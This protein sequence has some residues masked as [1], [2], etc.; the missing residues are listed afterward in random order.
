MKID[1][2]NE[3]KPLS[4][5]IVP[6][7]PKTGQIKINNQYDLA[8]GATEPNS[9]A[10]IPIQR[11][12]LSWRTEQIM[13]LIDVANADPNIVSI[14]FDISTPGG[15]VTNTDL[16][17]AKIKSSAKPTVGYV[18]DMVASAGMWIASAMNYRIASSALDRA[19]SIGTM[20]RVMDMTRMYRDK[21][22][23]DVQDVY[24][25]KSTDKNGWYR[26]FFN[27][28]L[29]KEQQQ[30]QLIEDLDFVNNH[31]HA[32]VIENLGLSSDSEVLTGK[33][34]H[35]EKAIELGLLNEINSMDYAINYAHKLGVENSIKS[36]IH[37][38]NKKQK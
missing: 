11:E 9:V 4:G 17:A 10:I 5:K 16:A 31:F 24:A 15:M 25:T 22:G 3:E 18:R 1:F 33:M 38:Q 8:N 12:I 23:I 14:L 30:Q 21:L 2:S 36:Y 34:Y 35:A 29:T 27:Q 19:G 7:D 37:S 28:D 20:A 32:A 6:F 26:E 13:Q